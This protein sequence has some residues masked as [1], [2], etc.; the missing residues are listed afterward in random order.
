MPLGFKLRLLCIDFW[1]HLRWIFLNR[2]LNL[3]QQGDSRNASCEL[4]TGKKNTCV[5]RKL[6]DK[7]FTVSRQTDRRRDSGRFREQSA[8][9]LTGGRQPPAEN[10]PLKN[11]RSKA[12]NMYLQRGV[13]NSSPNL[14]SLTHSRSIYLSILQPF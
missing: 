6:Y 9:A 2:I 3:C 14:A 1:Q 11:Q 7:R 5:L 8:K 10:L 13:N 4:R 12:L